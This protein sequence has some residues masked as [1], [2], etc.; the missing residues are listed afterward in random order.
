MWDR[1]LTK[2]VNQGHVSSRESL[3]GLVK[4]GE[5]FGGGEW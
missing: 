4:V 3:G 1:A 2:K 5:L